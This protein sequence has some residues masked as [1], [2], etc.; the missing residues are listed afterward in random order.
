MDAVCFFSQRDLSPACFPLLE[1]SVH[2]RWC[3][4]IDEASSWRARKRHARATGSPLGGG[5]LGSF[6]TIVLSRFEHMRCAY[7]FLSPSLSP[8]L[9]VSLTLSLALALSLSLSL[10]LVCVCVCHVTCVYMFPKR[11]KHPYV[12]CHNVVM[13]TL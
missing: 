3:C 6:R 2:T 5:P 11:I 1:A 4:F 10:S 13:V 12:C 9:A 8:S 7:L